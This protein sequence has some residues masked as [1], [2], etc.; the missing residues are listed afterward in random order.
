MT[1]KL[2]RHV[3]VDRVPEP[4]AARRTSADILRIP[5]PGKM[6]ESAKE[7]RLRVAISTLRKMGLRGILTTVRGGY[8]L[9]HAA[10][11]GATARRQNPIEGVRVGGVVMSVGQ[12][13]AAQ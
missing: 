10:R 12:P 5:V 2:P 4:V 6:T 1:R 9:R 13:F 7:A 8:Q 11:F 3:L